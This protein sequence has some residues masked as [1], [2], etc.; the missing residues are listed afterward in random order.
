MIDFSVGFF[1]GEYFGIMLF[2][3]ETLSLL[4]LLFKSND[5]L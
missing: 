5:K 3:S 2:L 1:Y 4:L